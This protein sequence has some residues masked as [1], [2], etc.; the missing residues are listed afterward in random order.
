MKVILKKF[1]NSLKNKQKTLFIHIGLHK[2]GT[3]SIQLFLHKNKESVLSNHGIYYLP[4]PQDDIAP[5]QHRFLNK[6]MIEDEIGVIEYFLKYISNAD[7]FIISSECFIEK[8]IFCEKL[9]TLKNLFDKT[10]ILVGLRRQD[11]WIESLYRFRVNNK[12]ENCFTFSFDEW[13]DMMKKETYQWY[14]PDYLQTLDYWSEFFGHNNIRIIPYHDEYLD[15]NIVDEFNKV[16]GIPNSGSMPTKIFVNQ[17]ITNRELTE[18]LRATNNILKPEQQKELLTYL[19]FSKK[20]NISLLSPKVRH[21]I[22]EHFTSVNSEISKKYNNS[23]PIFSSEVI[24]SEDWFAFTGI[25]NP[26]KFI[27][28][29]FLLKAGIRKA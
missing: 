21:E 26:N 10:I 28:E 12:Y 14:N 17:S 16:V 13:T 2:T 29:E 15:F 5:K 27:I 7:K 22:I 9:S 20:E 3:S 25:S 11:Y 18:Y 23:V 6:L 19:R 4:I 24:E 1:R 8:K